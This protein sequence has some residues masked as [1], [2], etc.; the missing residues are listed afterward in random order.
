MKCIIDRFVKRRYHVIVEEVD[1]IKTLNAINSHH[2][3]VPDMAVGNCGWADATKWFIHFTT[4]EH[5]WE[6][7]RNE[8]H[9][10]RVYECRDIPKNCIG[11]V[12]SND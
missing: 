12:Y 1:V 2:K 10:I 11:Q 8:L 5:K 3:I 4:T 6:I 7:I 9:V